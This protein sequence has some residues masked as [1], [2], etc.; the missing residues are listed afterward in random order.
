MRR[1]NAV[2]SVGVSLPYLRIGSGGPLVRSIQEQLRRSGF[3]SGGM[4]GIFDQETKQ[5]VH[6]LQSRQRIEADGIVGPHTWRALADSGLDLDS[7]PAPRSPGPRPPDPFIRIG[8]VGPHVGAIHA[9]LGLMNTTVF[10][11]ATEKAVREFQQQSGLATDGIVGKQ[12]WAALLRSG[13]NADDLPP[14]GRDKVLAMSDAVR[15]VYRRRSTEK[16][17]AY[18]VAA[19]LLKAHP[20]YADGRAGSFDV[21]AAPAAAQRLLFIE[22]L[23]RVRPL[24]DANLLDKLTTRTVIWGLALLDR[25]LHLRLG[26]DGFLTVLRA[27][28]TEEI[29]SQQGRVLLARADIHPGTAVTSDAWTA[30]DD[31]EHELYAETIAEFILDDRTRAPLTIGIKA[32]WGG[33]KTSLMKM[34]QKRLDPGAAPTP[35]EGAEAQEADRT[36]KSGGHDR[37]DDK[38]LKVRQLLR[39]TW[40]KTPEQAARKLQ[41]EDPIKSAQRTTV[42]FNAWK[43]GIGV[44]AGRMHER[45]RQRSGPGEPTSIPRRDI[46]DP[47][48]PSPRPSWCASRLVH[49]RP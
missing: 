48:S 7:L 35:L 13:L 44:R 34:I 39:D 19:D 2:S 29:L 16:L 40:A 45:D 5:A 8:S 4:N 12:T 17:T 6:A 38:H 18:D 21:G 49:D 3:L 32:P 42:W 36:S 14:F 22:W 1:G 41:P 33:G 28:R 25:Q 47:G 46:P 26:R 9:H 43:Y 11:V 20:E 31:L 27:H 15:L 24:F 30:R 10:D 23:T 37:A